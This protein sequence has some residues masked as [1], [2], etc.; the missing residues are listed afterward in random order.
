MKPFTK[1]AQLWRAVT[2]RAPAA[3]L[4]LRR[5]DGARIDRLSADWFATESSI[6][7]ELR[8]DLNNLRKRGRQLASNNDY[9]KKF[10]G[11][12]ENNLI[13]P[14]GIRLQAKVEDAPGKEDALANDAIEKAWDEWSSVCDVTGQLQLRDLCESITG[15][16]PAD[17]EFLVRMVR[18]TDARNRFNFALQIIDV[19]RIDTAYNGSYGGNTVIMG[20]EVDTY[21]RPLALHLF[22]SHPNDGSRT[23]RRRIRVAA[24]ELLHK[25]KIERA[26]QMRGV[27]WMAPGMLS[28]HH[29]GNFMLSALLAAEHGANH[30]GFFK[31]SEDASGQPPIGGIE[32]SGA[33]A[34]NISP[35]QPGTYDTLPVG[36]SYQAHDSKYP[37]EVFSPFAKT[38][39]QRIATGWRVAYHS[40]ANDLEGVSFSSI[41]SGTLEE[42]DRWM[43]DQQWFIGA[44]MEPVFQAWLQMALLSGA[45]TMPNGSALPAAKAAKF[46]KHEWQPRRWEWVDPKSDMEAKILSVKAG[47]MA[48]QD[49]SAAMGYDF[50]DTL[51]AI[52]SAQEM[53]KLYGVQ[54]T[55]YDAMP[56]ANSAGAAPAPPPPEPAAKDLALQQSQ[57]QARSL[58][59]MMA[60]ITAQ[61]TREAPAPVINLPAQNISLDSRQIFDSLGAAVEKIASAH[62]DKIRAIEENMQVTINVPEQ[63]APIVSVSVEAPTV[64]FEAAMPAPLVTVVSSHP[65]RAVQKVERDSNDEIVQTV[66]T[67]EV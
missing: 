42:R 8:A 47:L 34:I 30:Y 24:T 53:A 16:L 6:N 11:M 3:G 2:G 43:A 66:T 38:M 64:N 33:D 10:R 48:P 45:I 26:E 1:A 18:G 5:F 49:L 20:V 59:A 29:L 36:Y 52:K 51:K 22:E 15:S 65:T 13:G 31:Q 21:R 60:A 19:D 23:G 62:A 14:A 9:A 28:L 4:Q 39:L 61:A 12:V 63:L 27:P 58:D 54:L 44:F 56:G 7:E 55:A 40:L 50:E 41:R 17:G 46:A 25:F 57:Q 37:N 32:G 35:S 67:Y